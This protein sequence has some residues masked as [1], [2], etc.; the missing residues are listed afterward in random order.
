MTTLHLQKVWIIVARSLDYRGQKSGLSWPDG[1]TPSA[2][3]V[4]NQRFANGKN[5]F[6]SSIK[7]I[8]TRELQISR[9]APLAYRHSIETLNQWRWLR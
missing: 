4:C 5:R 3:A 8:K 2:Q 7:S 1:K 6:A 9:F